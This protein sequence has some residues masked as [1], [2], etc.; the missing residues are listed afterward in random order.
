MKL[1]VRQAAAVVGAAGLIAFGCSAA[2]FSSGKGGEISAESA[3]VTS[4]PGVKMVNVSDNTADAPVPGDTV[5]TGVRSF[6]PTTVYSALSNA[7]VSPSE[8]FDREAALDEEDDEPGQLGEITIEVVGV[9]PEDDSSSGNAGKYV[10]SLTDEEFD[11][12]C[13]V[14]MSEVGYCDDTLKLAI[15]NVIINRVRSDRFPDTVY[16]VLH[17]KNQFGAVDNYYTKRLVPD[18]SVISCVKR[19]LSGE[20]ASIVNGATFYYT[21]GVSSPK[22]AAWFESLCFCASVGNGRFFKAW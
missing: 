11:M 22:A 15:S 6:D 16:E 17:Q 21:P 20:G 19:A 1:S 8:A 9:A 14:V 3:E 2:A 13:A 12:M 5:V 7:D 4:F 10:I 18:E